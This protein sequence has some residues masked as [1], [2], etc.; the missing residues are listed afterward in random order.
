M[1]DG[2]SQSQIAQL[3]NRHKSTISRE[4]DRNTEL[5]DYCNTP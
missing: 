2:K 3:I 5:K 4:L 1:K